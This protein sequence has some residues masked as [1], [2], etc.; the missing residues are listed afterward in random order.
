MLNKFNMSEVRLLLEKNN[1]PIEEHAF[2]IQSLEYDMWDFK[3]AESNAKQRDEIKIIKN[4][5]A[6][7]LKNLRCL[8]WELST[9]L[10]DELEHNFSPELPL[11]D[12]SLDD[13]TVFNGIHCKF[14]KALEHNSDN[15]ILQNL[16]DEGVDN[17]LSHVPI[18]DEA[19]IIDYVLKL[20][21]ACQ[22]LI[23][24]KSGSKDK[25]L[26]EALQFRWDMIG[27]EHGIKISKTN[28]IAFISACTSKDLESSRKQYQRLRIIPLSILNS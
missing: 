28:S 7:L 23:D 19:N 9:E 21:S 18:Q 22:A 17:A 11:D 10:H 20:E 15:L 6:S 24:R 16:Y 26:Y 2:I 3:V 12:E 13:D 8:S 25:G 27:K 1:V 14:E 5:T 4:N